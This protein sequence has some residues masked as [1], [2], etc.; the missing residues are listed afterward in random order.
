MRGILINKQPTEPITRE[1]VRQAVSNNRESAMAVLTNAFDR[2][3]K[4]DPA[5]I[6]RKSKITRLIAGATHKTDKSLLLT[7]LN[8]RQQQQTAIASAVQE[9]LRLLGMFVHPD[10]LLTDENKRVLN[11]ILNRD[12]NQDITENNIREA[13]KRDPEKT[14]EQLNIAYDR[15]IK[16][17]ISLADRDQKVASLIHTLPEEKK[18]AL[19]SLNDATITAAATTLSNHRETARRV[20]IH[21]ET[22][23]TTVV[24]MLGQQNN[25]EH[26]ANILLTNN[27]YGAG[28]LAANDACVLKTL[29]ASEAA[30]SSIATDSAAMV[31]VLRA[32]EPGRRRLANDPRMLGAITRANTEVAA[33]VLARPEHATSA[34]AVLS[35]NR[36]AHLDGILANNEI[37]NWVAQNSRAYRDELHLEANGNML[38]QLTRMSSDCQNILANDI[39]SFKALILASPAAIRFLRDELLRTERQGQAAVPE[40][41]EELNLFE[42]YDLRSEAEAE[43][44]AEVRQSLERN[45]DINELYPI[46]RRRQLIALAVQEPVQGEN[47][48]HPLSDAM[49][50]LNPEIKNQIIERSFQN[51]ERRY[52][53]NNTLTND[54]KKQALLRSLQSPFSEAMMTHLRDQNVLTQALANSLRQEAA[55]TQ[56]DPI[57]AD[58]VEPAAKLAV[59]TEILNSAQAQN[60]IDNI[61]GVPVDEI[62][63]NN[64]YPAGSTILQNIA[65]DFLVE[66]QNLQHAT[67][68]SDEVKKSAIEAGL[69]NG[70]K[71]NVINEIKTTNLQVFNQALDASLQ[72]RDALNVV[73]NNTVMAMLSESLK[74]EDALGVKGGAFNL[75]A[76]EGHRRQ[77]LIDVVALSDTDAQVKQA[78]D[79]LLNLSRP[80]SL[81]AHEAI[82]KLAEIAQSNDEI[83]NAFQAILHTGQPL[84]DTEWD[85]TPHATTSINNAIKL[86]PVRALA[87][88]DSVHH[89]AKES[90][91][92]VVQFINAH[93]ESQTKIC[94]ILNTNPI[95]QVI[96]QEQIARA[97]E[98]NPELTAEAIDAAFAYTDPVQIKK[99]IDA[100]ADA[101]NVMRQH[102][103]KQQETTLKNAKRA[104]R[105][106]DAIVEAESVQ[107]QTDVVKM[108]SGKASPA[109]LFAVKRIV[110]A[111]HN[112]NHTTD[113]TVTNEIKAAMV[114]AHPEGIA[115]LV[116]NNDEAKQAIATASGVNVDRITEANIVECIQ[117]AY[118]QNRDD[119][120]AAVAAV[121]DALVPEKIQQAIDVDPYRAYKN[122]RDYVPVDPNN[123]NDPVTVAMLK[124]ITSRELSEK[125][126]DVDI[127]AL[128]SAGY[129][130][131]SDPFDVLNSTS[132]NGQ[133]NSDF[134]R[135]AILDAKKIALRDQLLLGIGTLEKWPG[136]EGV[137]IVYTDGR[138]AIE[139]SGDDVRAAIPEILRAAEDSAHNILTDNR[140]MLTLSNQTSTD[141]DS[142]GQRLQ[143]N[144]EN[145]KKAHRYAQEAS[146]PL[147]RLREMIEDKN[148][149]LGQLFVT[150]EKAIKES[151]E[152]I[153]T[154]AKTETNAKTAYEAAYK[155]A[156]ES[157][158]NP[159][160]AAYE[161][162][163]REANSAVSEAILGIR[164]RGIQEGGFTNDFF[165][166]LATLVVNDPKI[167]PIFS[168]IVAEL[169]RADST[170]NVDLTDHASVKEFLERNVDILTR[171]NQNI[172]LLNLLADQ[173]KLVSTIAGVSHALNSSPEVLSA[174]PFNLARRQERERILRHDPPQAVVDARARA[175]AR[176]VADNIDNDPEVK[177]V[178]DQSITNDM[179]DKAP[180]VQAALQKASAANPQ[181]IA[182]KTRYDQAKKATEK[183]NKHLQHLTSKVPPDLTELRTLEADSKSQQQ[184][185]MDDAK[186]LTENNNRKEFQKNA[187]TSGQ[188]NTN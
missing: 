5:D 103:K 2:L 179:L 90:L 160:H 32:N 69:H 104:N 187:Q 128:I 132:R 29:E 25:E 4:G 127:K 113:A 22:I 114:L 145:T 159:R 26:A 34:V 183:E 175:Q 174:Q 124:T 8:A 105:S 88:L 177:K 129:N 109:E 125:V 172:S 58:N 173:E 169:Q 144:L 68:F 170:I 154:L 43:A 45:N 56:N 96:A 139:L 95:P 51:Q 53:I 142:N 92:L 186:K 78:V 6:Q 110:K 80:E 112:L 121:P 33:D 59:V 13:L 76:D 19:V 39:D 49:V 87:I 77:A 167:R 31:S 115:E 71:V 73:D 106:S 83:Q 17:D 168:T 55:N 16:R 176:G 163:K 81:A 28:V 118:R 149:V 131:V 74:A 107:K 94:E 98:I 42:L 12:H 153:K 40:D 79:G 122:A 84:V 140:A 185:S 146:A 35:V 44:E 181:V 137:R 27:G 24:G 70:D 171:I 152:N 158:K 38:A 157:I 164:N 66:E 111:L 97:K 1:D 99:A 123:P 82:S 14:M 91:E 141:P 147:T 178:I 116:L 62:D 65:N 150:D 63:P 47:T 7:S 67:R 135:A 36:G 162:L 3:V 89:S 21:D 151:E 72:Q 180:A 10:G 166:E 138:D 165:P 184:Q 50:A 75:V 155:V 136:K 126:S 46:A 93:P 119:T 130:P 86:D 48:D 54:V 15:L 23:K 52:Y 102:N 9:N 20:I 133:L 41:Q 161:R 60:A 108:A 18:A 134:C 11:Q 37:M 100:H 30:R 156:E 148:S 101:N 57:N 188:T 61:R 85:T 143:E 117:Q 120:I 64:V 182:A